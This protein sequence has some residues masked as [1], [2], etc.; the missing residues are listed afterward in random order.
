MNGFVM[1]AEVPGN[2][3]IVV[4]SL[5]IRTNHQWPVFALDVICLFG[6]VDQYFTLVENSSCQDLNVSTLF[7]RISCAKVKFDI[8]RNE[9][10]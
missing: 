8:V 3:N 7:K 9:I 2:Y 10:I 5:I 6:I 4:A 1:I